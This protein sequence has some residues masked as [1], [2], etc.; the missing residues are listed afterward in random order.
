M[1]TPIRLSAVVMAGPRHWLLPL[2]PLAWLAIQAG[3]LITGSRPSF[4]PAAAQNTLIG[5]PLAVL[6]AFLGGRIIAGEMDQRT[7]EIAYTVPGGAHR[8]W[9][10]KLTAAG[11]MLLVSLGLMAAATFTFFTPFP[12]VPTLYGAGQCAA[13]HLVAAMGFATLFRSET[14]GGMATMALLVLNWYMAPTGRRSLPC[15][16][17]L[18]VQGAD[19]DQ[20]LAMAVQ[21]RIGIALVIAAIVALTF[22][23]ADGREKMLSG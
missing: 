21:N 4:E 2:A 7:L 12:I 13:F 14:A 16:N 23:R 3:L 15:W 11:L 8:V 10:G 18:T 17:P 20:L 9:L 19:E 6:A 5:F 1:I 22:A